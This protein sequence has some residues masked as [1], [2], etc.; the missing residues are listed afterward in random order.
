[1]LISIGCFG[2]GFILDRKSLSQRRRAQA[3]LYT[4]V[5][6]NVGVY[7][8]SIIMQ[9]KFKHHDPGAID[10][11]SGRC[12]EAIGQAIAYGAALIPMIMLVNTTPDHIPADL[13]TEERNTA[14]EKIRDV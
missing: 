9:S 13:V 10:W 1:M 12:I 2:L 8:W 6:L 3:G 4:V 5:I 14:C 7:V 11:D